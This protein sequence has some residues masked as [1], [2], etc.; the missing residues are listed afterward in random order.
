MA[1]SVLWVFPLLASAMTTPSEFIKAGYAPK[2]SPT[3]AFPL[4]KQSLNACY[5][6][7]VRNILKYKY[8]LGIYVSTVEKAIGKDPKALSGPAD[9][10]NFLNAVHAKIEESKDIAFLFDHLRD[11]DPVAISYLLP[12]RAKDGSMKTVPHVAAAYSFDTEGIWVAETVSNTYVRVP[13]GD[14][15]AQ[16][17]VRYKPLRAFTYVPKERW[18]EQAKTQEREKNFLEGE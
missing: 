15:F 5:F 4:K 3:Y 2:L 11:G 18:T 14:V 13:Y 9:Q 12:Y 10:K 6:Y 7:A 1:G 17:K 8:G 16:G